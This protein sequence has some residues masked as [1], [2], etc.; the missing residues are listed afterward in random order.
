LYRFEGNLSITPLLPNTMQN[1]SQWLI[2]G[3]LFLSGIALLGLALFRRRSENE[4]DLV[5]PQRND[6]PVKDFRDLGIVEVKPISPT[7]IVTFQEAPPVQVSAPVVTAPEEKSGTFQA[8]PLVLSPQTTTK[9]DI[10]TPLAQS[11][12]AAIKAHTV[13][14]VSRNEDGFPIEASV[15]SANQFSKPAELAA[16]IRF[17]REVGLTDTHPITLNLAKLGLESKD[18]GYYKN[19]V[20][21]SELAIVPVM[22]N[23]VK[24]GYWI[25]DRL[26]GNFY[27]KDLNTMVDYTHLTEDILTEKRALP[28]IQPDLHQS[29]NQDTRPRRDIIADAMNQAFYDRKPLTFAM[30]RIHEE[31]MRTQT[32]R[33]VEETESITQ[34]TLAQLLGDKG[35]AEYFGKLIKGVFY[36]GKVSETEQWAE[37]VLSVLAQTLAITPD[38]IS[39]G[40]VQMR[41]RHREPED[42][43][44]EA[45]Q[46]LIAVHKTGGIALCD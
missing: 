38:N 45:K 26:E 12:K 1:L 32:E 14:L 33:E 31:A 13:L 39:I 15:S 44:D 42:L 34:A 11:L 27:S 21:I 2:F 37:H 23:G 10:F 35:K 18:L 29:T 41:E 17:F 46:A 4:I 36:F 5:G 6:N 40:I 24:W 7:K 16:N 20:S 30:V 9:Q 43:L 3:L 19:T 25:A 22:K 8:K 28:E